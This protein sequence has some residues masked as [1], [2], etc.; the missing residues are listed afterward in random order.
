MELHPAATHPTSIV[1]LCRIGMHVAC[2]GDHGVCNKL[3]KPFIAEGLA[4]LGCC[5]VSNA[6]LALRSFVGVPTHHTVIQSKHG[7][8]LFVQMYK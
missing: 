6:L 8:L 3:K 2:G 4:M 7:S 5:E 1:V